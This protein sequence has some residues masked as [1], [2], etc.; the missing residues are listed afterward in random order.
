MAGLMALCALFVQHHGLGWA[1][2][3]SPGAARTG[4]ITPPASAARPGRVELRRGETLIGALQRAGAS[5][6]E[7][8]SV[9]AALS[10]NL[11]V[12]KVRAGQVVDLA[13]KTS[14]PGAA[15]QLQG[16]SLKTGPV[17]TVSAWRVANGAFASRSVCEATRQETA[18]AQGAL[19]DSLYLAAQRAGAD[20]RLVAEAVKLFSHRIDFSRDL[21]P[22]DHF[23]LVFDRKVAEGGRTV[24]TGGLVYAELEARG[25]VTRLYK[26][27]HD[28]K[29]QFFDEFGK[30]IKGFLLKT[31]VDAARVTSSFGMRFHPVLGYTR[32]HQGVDF[33]ASTGTPVYAAGDGVVQEMKWAGGYG[34]WLKISHTGGWSTGY[35][36][37]S[38]YARG[39]RVGEPIRQGQVV[40]YVGMTGLATGPHLHYEIMNHDR[41]LDPRKVKPQEASILGGRELA[42]FN[43]E[44]S[45]I[46]QLISAALHRAATP[47]RTA[48]LAPNMTGGSS[49]GGGL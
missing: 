30:N 39:L 22:D 7:A 2:A 11:D 31:P 37:L 33:G 15:L 9:V 29:T 25:K 13:F 4:S 38:A 3:R 35:G 34:R 8:H 27:S 43:A 42:A 24:E 12:R 47:V 10:P 17:S 32:M 48:Q 40:A 49:D 6:D 21:R 28:G 41:K 36:H 1:D 46:T 18:V 26:F 44:K 23:K 5:V 16:L 20:G 14:N 45:H 19:K